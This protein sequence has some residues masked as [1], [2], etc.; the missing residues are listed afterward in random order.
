MDITKENKN[1][2]QAR[3]I[4]KMVMELI[5]LWI[6]T[7]E[8]ELHGQKSALRSRAMKL[9]GL[10]ITRLEFDNAEDLLRKEIQEWEYEND[11]LNYGEEQYDWGFRYEHV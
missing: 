1:T 7:L 9:M 2:K 5:Q 4:Q 6:P 3:E 11:E 8:D 10:W